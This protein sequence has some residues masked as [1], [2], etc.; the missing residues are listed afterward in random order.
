MDVRSCLSSSPLLGQLPA[1]ALD[2]LTA[3][4]VTVSLRG[5]DTLF[6]AGDPTDAVYLVAVGRLRIA[7]PHAPVD[8]AAGD[9][10]GEV[11]A[12][13]DEA[14]T[15]TASALRDTLLL[16]IDAEAFRRVLSRHEDA[17]RALLRMVVARLRGAHS[18][19]SPQQR[20]AHAVTVL[21]LTEDADYAGVARALAQ[22]LAAELR[23]H[24][25]LLDRQ[26]VDRDLGPGAAQTRFDAGAA[27]ARLVSWLQALEG[28]TAHL[29][30][31]ADG[32]PEPWTLR[33]ARQADRILLVAGDGPLHT[34]TLQALETAATPAPRELVLCGA[35]ARAAEL[36][37][38]SGAGF[39]HHC[40]P[41]QPQTLRRL[42]RQVA[43]KATGL[44]LGGG[45]ARGFAHIGLLR[46]LEEAKLDIDMIGGTSMGAFIAALHAQGASP[47]AMRDICDDV[48]VQNN[49]LNDWVIPR[50]S[51]IRGRK[52][53]NKLRS[54][55]GEG[56]IEDLP[57]P[58]YCVSTN[59]TR[60][61]PQVHREGK[62][63]S[64]VGTSMCVPGIAP[65]VV[66]QGE[67]LADG[68]VVNSVPV[69]TMHHMDRGPVIACD[70]GAPGELSLPGI[71]GPA[72]EALLKARRSKRPQLSDILM[73]MTTMTSDLRLEENARHADLFLR[74]PVDT[75][76][77]F[78]WDALDETI[79]AGYAHACKVLE[80]A[81]NDWPGEEGPP[82]FQPPASWTR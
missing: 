13:T 77:M 75:V 33:V 15:A 25:P 60:G 46:A 38:R 80:A 79:E 61:Q 39:L 34:D 68:A 64:W 42:A 21:P 65:P 19:R 67:L 10:V 78:S 24:V 56:L 22:S 69:D 50:V 12:L 63:A 17:Q 8:I 1:V 5:G 37:A 29:V 76:N 36:M 45:G 74:M 30:A 18:G 51:L 31:A 27:N 53:L 47:Q 52:F 2:A 20:S 23:G 28:D 55:L 3:E 54:V 59:L 62:L 32:V 72:P 66:Y 44:V 40:D 49:H 48:F 7:L 70:V 35:K 6:E 57:I 9:L 14:R 82:S 81:A 26:A 11:G 43:G 73:R 58:F 41:K 71:K 16:K 4:A